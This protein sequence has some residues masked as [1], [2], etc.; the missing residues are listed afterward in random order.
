MI[1]LTINYKH[2]NGLSRSYNNF[3][4]SQFLQRDTNVFLAFSGRY[5]R[6]WLLTY[7]HLNIQTFL[8]PFTGQILSAYSLID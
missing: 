5:L 1:G 7:V 3:Y 8:H 6:V 4:I 2:K